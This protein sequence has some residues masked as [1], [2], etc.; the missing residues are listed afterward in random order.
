LK[1]ALLICPLVLIGPFLALV[2][3][4]TRQW[5][6]INAGTVAAFAGTLLIPA[7][8]LVAIVMTVRAWRGGASRWLIAYACLVSL[9]MIGVSLYFASNRLMGLRT[10]SY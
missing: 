7:A 9:A 8:A 4:P 10:W 5:G 6:T 1:L 3:T 2:Q